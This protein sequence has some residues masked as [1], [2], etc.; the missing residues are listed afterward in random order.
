[1]WNKFEQFENVFPADPGNGDTVSPGTPPRRRKPKK[2]TLAYWFINAAVGPGVGMIYLSVGAHGTRELLEV[3]RMR[4]YQLP[5]PSIGIIRGYDGWNR[6]DLALVFA[7]VLCL[8]VSILWFKIFDSLQTP[9]AL[10][11]KRERSPVLFYLHAAICAIVI[12]CDSGLFFVGLSSSSDGWTDTPGY[13]PL[14]AT[15]LF[16]ASIA[17]WGAWHADHK[18]AEK[19]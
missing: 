1:M 9:G 5:I 7:G 18:N 17:L 6:L 3:T 15:L 19:V 14:L 10:A 8:A 4:L 13:V 2:E 12:V 16:T 11:A